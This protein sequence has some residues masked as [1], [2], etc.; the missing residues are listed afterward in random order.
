[1]TSKCAT[2]RCDTV[3]RAQ[4]IRK[5][6]AKIRHARHAKLSSTSHARKADNVEHFAEADYGLGGA[7]RGPGDP[8][9]GVDSSHRRGAARADGVPGREYHA[10]PDQQLHLPVVSGLTGNEAHAGLGPQRVPPLVLR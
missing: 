10:E 6:H 9:P 4:E 7:V 5:N 1:M 8:V 2:T 3:R